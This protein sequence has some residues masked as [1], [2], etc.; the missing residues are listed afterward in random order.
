M[1]TS[2]SV[3][4]AYVRVSS[5]DQNESRQVTAI[6]KSE[7]PIRKIYID[8]ST[9]KNMDRP[10]FKKLNSNLQSGD[11][12]VVQSIDRLGRNMLEILNYIEHLATNNV[13]FICL[14]NPI[15]N[16]DSNNKTNRVQQ[17]IL[18]A[19]CSGF[20][21]LE[22]ELIRKRQ[23]EG[24]DRAKELGINLGRKPTPKLLLTQIQTDIDAGM[25]V[26]RACEKHGITKKTYYNHKKTLSTSEIK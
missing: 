1:T 8:K 20:A 10:E 5:I 13:N 25:P 9:G 24:I 26:Y 23:R 17:K 21:E 22:R 15:F 16:L 12:L 14:D 7:Y 19:M 6:E 2:T 18:L 3:C 11:T 4:F